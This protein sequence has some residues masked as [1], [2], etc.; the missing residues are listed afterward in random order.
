MNPDKSANFPPGAK[1]WIYRAFLVVAGL[2]SSVIVIFFLL[3]LGDGSVSS[4]NIEIWLVGLALAA[5]VPLAGTFLAQRGHHFIAT[6]VLGILALPG[7][8]SALFILL[9]ILSGEK[10]I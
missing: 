10:W 6:L 3:G 1:L 7:F 4:L 2:T 9:F 5:G 8:L